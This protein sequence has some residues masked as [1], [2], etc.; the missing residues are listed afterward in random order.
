[1]ERLESIAEQIAKQRNPP[2]HLWHPENIGTIDIRIN[3][4]GFWFHE[5]D[6]IQREE[7]VRLFASIL[8]FEDD[9]HFLVT[10]VEKL[11]IDVEDVPFV[12]QQMEHVRESGKEYWVAVSNTHEQF[13]VSADHPVELRQYQGEWVPYLNLRYQLWA[14]V[15]RSIYYQWVTAA[16]DRQE[17]ENAPLTLESDGYE[18]EVARNSDP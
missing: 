12:I 3:S 15:N 4:Q 7:L 2:V 5:G 13:I 18:F 9:Q 1:M 14:R 16:M 6:P 8:W 10:P 17:S 11:S